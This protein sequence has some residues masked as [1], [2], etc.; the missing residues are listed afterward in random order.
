[1][2]GRR[3]IRIPRTR[4]L[5][6]LLAVSAVALVAATSGS[7][8]SGGASGV[9]GVFGANGWYTSNVTVSYALHAHTPGHPDARGTLTAVPFDSR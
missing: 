6:V 2:S 8:W 5:A 7:A 9:S 1:M 4:A 3:S